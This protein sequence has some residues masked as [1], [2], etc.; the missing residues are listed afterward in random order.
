MSSVELAR[1]GRLVDKLRSWSRGFA[2]RM[3]RTSGREKTA[4]RV[5]VR[6]RFMGRWRDCEGQRVGMVPRGIMRPRYGDM[7]KI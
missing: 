5:N 6:E 4:V 3:G 7:V 1:N 2:L